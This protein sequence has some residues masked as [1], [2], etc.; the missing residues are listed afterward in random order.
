MRKQLRPFW[1]D[2]ELAEIY[3][4]P[5]EHTNWDAHVE[6]VDNTVQTTFVE[7]TKNF[8]LQSPKTIGDMAAGDGAIASQLGKYLNA[9]VTLGDFTPR[10]DIVGP[11]EK[12][13]RQMKPVDLLVMTEI[14]EHLKNPDLALHI[15][16]KRAGMLLVSTPLGEFDASNPEHYWGWEEDDIRYM[17][18]NA[19]WAPVRQWNYTP[20]SNDYYTFQN[21]IAI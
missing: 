11:I 21:W 17:L 3:R 4:H 20:A 14:L 15:A 13:L 6:R 7:I 5:F 12:T 2:E 9:E 8:P 16:R 1:T 18:R 10:Y 19:G